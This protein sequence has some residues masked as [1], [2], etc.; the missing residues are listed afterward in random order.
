M[1]LKVRR[2]RK[3]LPK[4][5]YETK[6]GKLYHGDCLRIM[7]L[8]EQ[9]DL[10][11]TDPPYGVGKA[12]W[13]T[14]FPKK[15]IWKMMCSR[16]KQNGN[17]LVIPG[18]K[19]L[20]QKIKIISSIF[21]YQW[22]IPWYKPNAMQFG[23]TGFSKYNLIWW[24][25]KGKPSYKPK[26]V[27]VI[28]VS[29]GRSEDKIK[30]HPTPKPLLVIKHLIYN[31]KFDNCIVLDP[32]QG[33]GTVPVACEYLGVKWIAIEKDLSFCRQSSERIKEEARRIKLFS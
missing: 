12:K 1:G 19:Y 18:E 4:P 2:K 29:M 32:Y 5:Y 33:S 22:I 25:S 26:M 16:L 10:I 31:F 11:V 9:A 17:L 15:I 6:L 23:K 3:I 28:I 13:D 14:K 24:F 8:L 20:P 21:D 30:W 27:D 7:P